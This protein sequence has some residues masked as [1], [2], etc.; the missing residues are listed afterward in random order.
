MKTMTPQQASWIRRNVWPPALHA[1]EQLTSWKARCSCTR[2]VA[3][4]SS[5]ACSSGQHELCNWGGQRPRRTPE[6]SLCIASGKTYWFWLADVWELHHAHW[7]NCPCSCHTAADD[8]G[9]FPIAMA[10]AP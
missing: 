5:A 4:N 7:A 2:T 10:T 3:E 8:A 1:A 6:G 9:L